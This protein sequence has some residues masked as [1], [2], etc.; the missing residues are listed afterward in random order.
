[1]AAGEEV[2]DGQAIADWVAWR[3]EHLVDVIQLQTASESR[4]PKRICR[5]AS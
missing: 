5:S 2:S 1:V 4:E 3:D